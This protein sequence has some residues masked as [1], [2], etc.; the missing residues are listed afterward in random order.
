[1]LYKD[2]ISNVQ[3]RESK[4]SDGVASGS[5]NHLEWR[6]QGAAMREGTLA[7]PSKTQQQNVMENIKPASDFKKREGK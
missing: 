5:H 7:E 6:K 3:L 1:M 4:P 2:K